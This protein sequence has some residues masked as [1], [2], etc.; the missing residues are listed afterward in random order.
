MVV[1][2]TIPVVVLEAGV[3]LREA[4]A[5]DTSTTLRLVFGIISCINV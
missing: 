4:S 3:T 5:L 2:S 1:A